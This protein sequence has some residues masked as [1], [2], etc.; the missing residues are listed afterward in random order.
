MRAR[1]RAVSEA[2]RKCSFCGKQGRPL[3]HHKSWCIYR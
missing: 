1:L 2:V 3:I